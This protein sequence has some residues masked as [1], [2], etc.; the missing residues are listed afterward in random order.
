MRFSEKTIAPVL[1]G[2]VVAASVIS[3]I[4]AAIVIGGMTFTLI[5]VIGGSWLWASAKSH[6]KDKP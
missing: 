1:L 3:P 4:L 5:V 2:L 6:E